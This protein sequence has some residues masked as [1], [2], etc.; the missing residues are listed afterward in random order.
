[1][2]TTIESLQKYIGKEVIVHLVQD[3]NSAK[4]F[5]GR[6]EA[7][8]VAGIVFKEKGKSGMQLIESPAKIYEI[9]FAPVKQKA[10]VQ[11][12]LVPV[13]FGQA[14][15][16]LVDRHGVELQWAKDADEKAA[17]EY[18]EGLDHTNLGHKHEAK[19]EKAKDERE[20]A[21]ES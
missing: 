19:D 3:D 4:E 15:Q 11:K 9:D 12:K 21:L 8:T 5:T 17:F 1:M 6:I 2:T 7:A 10:V 14:R 18:H 20:Q 16:H 13:E